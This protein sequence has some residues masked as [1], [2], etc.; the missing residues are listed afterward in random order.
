MDRLI[1]AF[2]N[3]KTIAR[4][5]EMLASS[6]FAPRATHRTGADVVRAVRDMGGG[7]VVCGAR[8]PDMTADQIW[9]DLEGTARMLVI[10]NAAQLAMC[11]EPKLRKLA[12]PV[13]R[14]LLAAAVEELIGQ[15][16]AAPRGGVRRSAQEEMLVMQA[17]ALLQRKY[18]MT[19]GE[20]HRYLQKRSMDAGVR[21]AATAE[22]LVDRHG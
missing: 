5:R 1:V 12:L 18:G 14:S 10:G 8:F 7:A 20:A 13:S 2:E 6:S 11:T 3:E 19:E 21:I 22:M 9:R 4:V 15:A 17:K 16:G